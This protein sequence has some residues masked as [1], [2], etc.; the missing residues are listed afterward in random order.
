MRV[1]RTRVRAGISESIGMFASKPFWNI[2]NMDVPTLSELLE[3]DKFS[4]LDWWYF[5]DFSAVS[6]RRR[7]YVR[8]LYLVLVSNVL[9]GRL[10]W[11]FFTRNRSVIPVLQHWLF[12][13]YQPCFI[14]TLTIRRLP[15]N[16]TIIAVVAGYIIIISDIQVFKRE[17]LR[18]FSWII[19]SLRNLKRV[20]TTAG[21]TFHIWIII[22]F[23]NPTKRM[24]PRLLEWHSSFE[25]FFASE[26]QESAC[27]YHCRDDILHLKHYQFAKLK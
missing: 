2:R 4:W 5:F 26:T 11:Q 13:E 19:I 12:C 1:S 10:T 3:I 23:E 27:F 15:H 8:R 22:R 18:F 17:L 25:S 14:N 16:V 6:S 21:M 9:R 7:D 24:L 20:P